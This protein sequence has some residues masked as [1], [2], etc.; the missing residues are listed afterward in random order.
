M[1]ENLARYGCAIQGARRLLVAALMLAVAASARAQCYSGPA[2]IYDLC[3]TTTLGQTYEYQAAQSSYFVAAD[4]NYLISCRLNDLTVFDV[5]NPLA[6]VSLA[7]AHI[8][9][10]WNDINVLGSTHE[11]FFSHISDIATLTGSQ[12]GLTMLGAYGWDVLQLNGSNS[13]FLGHG[14]QPA[15]SI[16]GN[17]Y[18]T[19]AL[20]QDGSTIYAVAQELD[21]TSINAADASLR[22][23]AI[24]GTAPLVGAID[25]STITPVNIQTVARVPVGRPTDPAGFTDAQF[26]VALGL[27]IRV[28]TDAAGKR[29]LLARTAMAAVVVDITTPSNPIPLAVVT[30]PAL[31]SGPWALDP[32]RSL[33]W[34][35]GTTT[36][37]VNGYK[38]DTSKL[39]GA[40][41][42]VLQP[43]YTNVN[44]DAA[45]PGAPVTTS[46]ANVAVAGDLLVAW[47]ARRVG[48][49]GLGGTGQPQLLPAAV[50]FTSLSGKV[51]LNSAYSER[52]LA[53]RPFVVGGAYYVCRSMMVDADIVGVSGSCMA[54]TPVPNFTV[55]GGEAAASCL[56]ATGGTPDARGFP[57]DSFTIT[58]TSGGQWTS[59]TLDIQFQGQSIGGSF[60][61]TITPRQ[62]VTWTPGPATAPGDYTVVL[63][64]FTPAATPAS[65]S[66][67]IML[68]AAPVA[69]AQVTGVAIDGN[70]TPVP[71][72]TCTYLTGDT[73]Q[74]SAAAPAISQG[75]PTAYTWGVQ[76]ALTSAWGTAQTGATI[77]VP[78]ASAGTYTAFV[79]VQY[80]FPGVPDPVSCA[81]APAAV[82][83]SPNNYASCATLT[84]PS[85]PFSVSQ[86][87]VT[88][89]TTTATAATNAKPPTLLRGNPITFS[90]TYRAASTYT[91]S[92][93]WGLNNVSTA[94]AP[95]ADTTSTPGT[96]KG[97]IPANTLPIS[98][99][100]NAE[101]L[102]A[103]ATPAGGGQAVD[104]TS[105]ATPVVF[106]V[107][108]CVTPGQATNTAP[109][110]GATNVTAG[111]V[112]FRWTAPSTGTGPFTYEVKP[113]PNPFNMTLCSSVDPTTSCAAPVS[114]GTTLRWQVITHS[115]CGTATSA[116]TSTSFTT[117]SPPTPTPTPTPTPPPSGNLSVSASPNPA[118]AGQIVT[119]SFSPP[120]SRAGDSLTFY[121]GDG[122][123]QTV[124]YP[125]L[126]CG[127]ASHTYTN[128]NTQTFTVSASGITGGASVSGSTSLT[129]QVVCT[130]LTAPA[131]SFTYSP[132]QVRAGKP[133][134]FLDTST[135]G[136]TSW[137]WSF[138][139][140][141][142]PLFPGHT[143]SQQSPTNT[144]ANVGTYTIT[145]TAT[146]CKGSSTTSQQITVLSACDQ[147]AAPSAS[148]TWGPQ[149]PLASYPA[150][151]Q[152]YV[153]QQVTLTD[154]STNSPTSWTWWDFQ[155][156]QLSATTVTVPT[157]TATWMQSGDKNVRMKATNCVG[158]SADDLE[159][160][161][162][163]D[164][165]RPVK[166]DFSWSGGTLATGTPV[167]F[168]ADTGDAYGNPDT[169]V[170]T[171]DDGSPQQTG[172]STT[173]TFTCGGSR[174][175]TL[176]A[177]RSSSPSVASA[178]AAHALTVTGTQCGPDAV[179]T[180][181]AA[182]TNGLNGTTWL[183]DVR[184][185]NPSSQPSQITVQLLPVGWNNSSP[186][187]KV[188]TLL[189]HATWVLNNVLL[190]AQSEG[191][192]GTD[193][194]K[195]A[196][197]IVYD[198]PENVAP[199][200]VSETYTSAPSGGGTYGQLTPGIEVV[201]N[202]TPPV[203][204]I[205]GI[206][207]NGTKSGFRTNYSLLNLRDTAV[208][209]LQFTLLDP[210]GKSLA[211]QS[212][213][214]GA[215]EYRQDSLADLFG[216]T[217]AATS[218][219]PMAV[220][221]VVPT[222]SD[223]QAYASV[224]DNLT[225]DPVLVPAVPPPSAPIFLPAVAYTA[226]ANG[227]VWRSDLQL[228]NSD[229][230]DH[231]W[232]VTY[233]PGGNGS[234]PIVTQKPTIAAQSTVRY[235]DLLSWLYGGTLTD[236]TKTSGVVEITPAD[237]SSAYPIVQARSFNQTTDGTFGQNIPPI[238]SDMGVAA[239]QGKRLLLTGMSSQD[240]ARTNL[241]FVS[242]SDTSGVNFA[243]VFYDENGDALNPKD[244]Q[245]N[246]VPYTFALGPNG[247]DQDKLENRFHNA[248]WSALPANL[249]AI[250][251]I[252]QVTDG[253][254][255][256]VYAT[257]IDNLTGDPNF[258]LAQPAP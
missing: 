131:A 139:D 186:P 6:A 32:N 94:P 183:T 141:A 85:N 223:V 95:T 29:I 197:R 146:N 76:D 18:N 255:G 194:K 176:T 84:L 195:A 258:I 246:P 99:G 91:P 8:P 193:V 199:I 109:S 132:A 7:N 39:P 167:T 125:C 122:Q 247:W 178:T 175:V 106:N 216:G 104:L 24:G 68:C 232:A 213:N 56:L 11:Q 112:T 48:Y 103:I 238:T 124:S 63:G 253:G 210:T 143:S 37:V 111:T 90:A 28:M 196:L 230:V 184:I 65:T 237:G 215:F 155:E 100:N 40:S 145:L 4:R 114:A 55:N 126:A 149:G 88:D 212:V 115:S 157:F 177:S 182:K 166:A 219:D 148:F 25:T 77:A 162:I 200:L 44:Y 71:C 188:A 30:D 217:T 26:P 207:N 19:S 220:K 133:V 187:A 254:P 191:I 17:G 229:S 51:C 244:G 128:T 151:Q 170:W 43:Q 64:N 53:T 80:G 15:V 121:F 96:V 234:L 250:S 218:P 159:V 224:V 69:A 87:T 235:D 101:F 163:Y 225:G 22:I 67:E 73:V 2:T 116:S 5:S 107:T 62:V 16:G 34:V 236:A 180:V 117:A 79:A 74:L 50:P 135:G 248:G 14:Y 20:F 49:L 209:N 46:P 171:F 10:D 172:A 243:V 204:W 245:G 81:G 54:T 113:S 231:T 110:S 226:G 27:W 181:D 152:P 41:P 98:T 97:V 158:T 66:K 233:T 173:H 203:L 208:S 130:A 185:F 93:V 201:P 150:Q 161:H 129:V 38:L 222:N 31:M 13:G 154:A 60:P 89:G 83:L 214:L 190:W 221:V 78:L 137:S 160:V 75:N 257:V 82:S 164:D 102:Q 241:G 35:A 165:I 12:Y 61:M 42:L 228:T 198:N 123:S 242:L 127:V 9:W 239:G 92:F 33:V 72:T 144:F 179:M 47:D 205:T 86:I 153:G 252:I 57:G 169:F 108:D 189:P 138:G 134:Q 1:R 256:T 21:Q 118:T 120:L 251:A 45:N 142:P 52:Y 58:D 174:T 211:T 140:G 156:L 192:V 147:T 70:G 168:T 240:I 227:T 105:S 3:S 249:R 119:F 136:P 23:Y 202:T 206:R 59:A 36:T